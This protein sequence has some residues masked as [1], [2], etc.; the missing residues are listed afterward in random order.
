MQ[1]F[2][3]IGYVFVCFTV[4]FRNVAPSECKCILRSEHRV[5]SELH[6][7]AATAGAGPRAGRERQA[8]GKANLTI[9]VLNHSV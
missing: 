3:L 9:H 6:P 2:L 5:Q 1:T 4:C 7:A 8:A